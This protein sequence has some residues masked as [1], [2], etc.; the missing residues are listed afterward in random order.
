M[1]YIKVLF[2]TRGYLWVHFLSDVGKGSSSV[3]ILPVHHL[4]YVQLDEG[5]AVDKPVHDVLLQSR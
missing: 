5:L 3:D 2:L 1:L 4:G